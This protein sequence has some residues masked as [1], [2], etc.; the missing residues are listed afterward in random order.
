M[1]GDRLQWEGAGSMGGT[2]G[3]AREL[4]G[5]AFTQCFPEVEG[6][7]GRWREVEGGGGKWREVEGSGGRWREVEGG[8]GLGAALSHS[9]SMPPTPLSPY[10]GTHFPYKLK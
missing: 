3:E 10:L 7:E 4:Q 2:G 1:G 6:G 9:F 8:G 5:S